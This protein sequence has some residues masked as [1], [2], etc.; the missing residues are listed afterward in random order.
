MSDSFAS[1]ASISGSAVGNAAVAVDKPVYE[2]KV[3]AQ[4]RAYATGRRKNSSARVWVKNGF[5]K[6]IVNGKDVT[7]YFN[8]PVLRLILKQPLAMLNVTDR[9]DVMCTVKGGGLSGQAGA[10]RHGIGV[11]LTRLDPENRGVMKKN[12]CL[13]RDP[14]VVERKKYGQKKARARFQFSK[15]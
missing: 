9:I 6:I 11:A 7:E 14:R 8:R 13:T 15:R 2:R 3:D 12:G 4:G 1:L 5:G 10:I